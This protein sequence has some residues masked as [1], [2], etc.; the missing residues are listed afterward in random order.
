[1]SNRFGKFNSIFPITVYANRI[2][3]IEILF[4]GRGH[5]FFYHLQRLY[6]GLRGVLD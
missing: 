4:H 2:R 3:C 5:V 1:M 6:H